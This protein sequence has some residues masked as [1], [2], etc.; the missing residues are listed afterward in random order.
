MTR[1]ENIPSLSDTIDRAVA[2]YGA[3]PVLIRALRASLWVKRPPPL[4]DADSLPDHLRRDVG[5]GPQVGPNP[6]RIFFL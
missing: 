6:D 2:S 4:T 3:L 1:N 5:L